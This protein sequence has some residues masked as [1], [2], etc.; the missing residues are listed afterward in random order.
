MTVVRPFL[1]WAGGKR[2]ILPL[3]LDIFPK[4]CGTY[5]EPFVGGG[6]AFFGMASRKNFHF[7]RAILNDANQELIDCYRAVRSFPNDLIDQLKCWEVNR[8]TFMQLRELDPNDISPARRA[9]RTIYLNKLCFNGLYRVNKKGKFNVS[10]GRW[11]K[12]PKTLDAPNLLKCSEALNQ[13]AALYCDDFAKVVAP[14]VEDDLVYF[15]PPYAP[16]N[17][18]SN[19]TSYTKDGFTYEDQKRLAETFRTLVDRG[20]KVVLS[21]SN[22][23]HIRDLYNGFETHEVAARRCINSRGDKRGPVKE[24]VIIGRRERDVPEIEWSKQED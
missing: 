8:E 2:G 1:K 9:A 10:Y 23:A 22:T 18:T 3:L 7:G 21:N 24:L 4:Q 11:A 20:V 17:A 15:D 5:Y 19:F 12:T 13:Y 6:A 16:L 14:A